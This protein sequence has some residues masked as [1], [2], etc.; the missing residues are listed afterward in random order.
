VAHPS[1]LPLG[2]PGRTISARAK[3]YNHR[4]GV[5]NRHRDGNRIGPA[6]PVCAQ[7]SH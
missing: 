6:P 4:I 5:S 1:N 7:S 2:G 3:T